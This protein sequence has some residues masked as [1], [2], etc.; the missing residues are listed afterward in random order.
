[1]CPLHIKR[2]LE[3]ILEARFFSYLVIFRKGGLFQWPLLKG[4]FFY[5]KKLAIFGKEENM[6]TKVKV[7]VTYM[8]V[9]SIEVESEDLTLDGIQSVIANQVTDEELLRGVAGDGPIDGDLII[10]NS[11]E[12][13]PDSDLKVT[14]IFDAGKF[15][16]N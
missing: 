12:S 4:A 13:T 3:A 6:M 7:I 16:N 10:I 8:L 11:I 9:G 2:A 5:I 1:M 14:T 15:L